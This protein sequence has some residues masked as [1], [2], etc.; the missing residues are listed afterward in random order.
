MSKR[1]R[2]G[3]RGVPAGRLLRKHVVHQPSLSPSWS[4]V[5]MGW[6]FLAVSGVSALFLFG[7]IG[8]VKR[9]DV[10]ARSTLLMFVIVFGASG[11]W[12]VVDGLLALRKRRR[13]LEGQRLHPREPWRW[14]HPWRTRVDDGA[15]GRVLR[16]FV[17]PVM[18]AVILTP[19][20]FLFEFNGTFLLMD[21]LV[22]VVTLK[23]LYLLLRYA[24]FGRSVLELHQVPFLVGETL[25]AKLLPAASLAR[26]EHVTVTLRCVQER[27]EELGSDEEPHVFGYGLYSATQRLDASPLRQGQPLD[28]LF[29]LPRTK[30]T[31]GTCM[32]A[33]S[34]IF[35]ELSVD[36]EL[37]GVDYHATFLV[38][39]YAPVEPGTQG[40]KQ[41]ARAA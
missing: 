20:H 12:L 22:G 29:A 17:H 19:F 21:I 10:G 31:P 24:R 2:R 9:G 18:C 14:E 13:R 25:K 41:G 8:T 32:T 27:T 33:F 11:L 1:T 26:L 40:K 6:M 39:V 7:V 3:V 37:R 15:L 30:H 38:P 35:W 23:P 16:A 5:V 34:P 28:I 36:A 4:W